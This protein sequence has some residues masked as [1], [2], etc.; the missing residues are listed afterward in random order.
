[1]FGLDT[2][3]LAFIALAGFS[4]AALVYA[5]LFQK[6]EDATK[7]YLIMEFAGNYHLKDYLKLRKEGW[8][9]PRETKSLFHKIVKGV[10]HIHSKNIVHRDLKLQNIV[11]KN[12]DCP[13]IVDFGFS[14]KGL[15]LN[16]DDHCGTPNYM[17]PELLYPKKSRKAIYADIW[18]LGIM[19]FYLLAEEYPFKGTLCS[20]Q[21]KTKTSSSRRSKTASQTSA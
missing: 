10:E 17:A 14:R 19:L 2:N 9:K 21:A 3:T 5:L 7:L 13:K 16:F 4:G 6:I 15:F 20:A 1:M 8:I 12:L 11:V 18:A